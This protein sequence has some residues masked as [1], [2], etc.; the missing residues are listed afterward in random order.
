MNS[1]LKATALRFAG[2]AALGFILGGASA[3]PAIAG[4]ESYAPPPVQGERT[5][6]DIPGDSHKYFGQRSNQFRDVGR[7]LAKIDLDADFNYDGLIDNQDPADNGAFQQTPPGLVIGTGELTRLV[8]RLSPYHLDFRGQAVVSLQVDGVNRADKTGRF[9]SLE[10]EMASTGHI[11][12]WRDATKR[13]LIL[14]SRDP[15]RRVYEWTV[16]DNKYPANI[17]GIV[18]RSLYL[19]GVGVAGGASGSKGGMVTAYSGDV[20][21]LV[22]VFHRVPGEEPAPV[23]SDPKSGLDAKGGVMPVE[24]EA[25]DDEWCLPGAPTRFRTSYDH[26]LVTVRNSGHM[27]EFVADN[28]D[29][30]WK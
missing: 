26:I 6:L 29:G 11:R 14:D 19:E 3:L 22:T 17:P 21:L 13:E 16:D 24:P 7:R 15:G 12:V 25:K 27:K 28:S 5:D 30:V 8:L 4:D 1:H 20:R 2:P 18:P 9:S 23:Y 10:E